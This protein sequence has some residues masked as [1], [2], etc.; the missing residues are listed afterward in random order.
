MTA[1]D[2]P[3]A[4][5]TV[6]AAAVIELDEHTAA[7]YIERN[8][9]LFAERELKVEIERT[10]RL[11]L[12]ETDSAKRHTLQERQTALKARLSRLMKTPPV[13]SRPSA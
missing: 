12:D 3:A 9:R 11:M 8:L 2:D 1:L 5:E 7:G 6:A 13:K 4:K 10:S